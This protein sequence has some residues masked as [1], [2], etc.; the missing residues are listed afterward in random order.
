MTA[1]PVHSPYTIERTRLEAHVGGA[2]Q[3]VRELGHGAMG[4]VFLARDVALHRLVAIKV[5][6]H[7][8]ATNE[9]Q[10][11]RFRREA[12]VTAQLHDEGILAVHGFGEHDDLVYIVMEYVYGV[13]L[14]RLI[15][16][17]P[18]DAGDVRRTLVTLARTLDYAHARGIVHRDLKPEN[19]LID[20]ET[21]RP[22][23]TDFGVALSRSADPV[24][25][26]SSRAYGTP[27]FMSPEQAAGELDIDGRSDV[28]ALGVLGFLMLTGKPPFVGSRYGSIASQHIAAAP[29]SVWSV[30]PEAPAD[31]VAA[32]EKCL[33]KDPGVRW[34][35]AG[36]LADSIVGDNNH[37]SVAGWVTRVGRFAAMIAISA[38]LSG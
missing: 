30:A 1:T 38:W 20:H 34:Q 18:M 5:L 7:E 12:R 25:S 21:G 37:T 29:P 35:S 32:I 8:L 19:V 33:E 11:E 15:D 3:V 9:E 10:R 36:E 6:R 14:S 31:L 13:P 4:V 17:G 26:E 22:R 2:Y 23:L 28:Y 16:Q 24:R 27:L